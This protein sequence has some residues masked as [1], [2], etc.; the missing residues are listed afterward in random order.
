MKKILIIAY[1]F[2]PIHASGVYR[3]LKFAKYLRGFG[4]EPLI[5]TID[6]VCGHGKDPG[7]LRDLPADLK[8]ER[9]SQWDFYRLVELIK[10]LERRV[11]KENQPPESKAFTAASAEKAAPGKLSKSALSRLKSQLPVFIRDLFFVPDDSIPWLPVAVKA[12]TKIIRQEK[13]DVVMTTSPPQSAHLVG[14]L[15]K[16]MTGTPWVVDFRDLWMDTFDFYDKAFGKWRKPLEA[17]MERKVIAQADRIINISHGES[18]H[19]QAQYSTQPVGKFHVIHNGYDRQD[20]SDKQKL[21]W[22]INEKTLNEKKLIVTYVGT[23]YPTTGDEFFGVLDRMF[24]ERPWLTREFEFRF[25]GHI[26]P[27]YLT[28]FDT[29]AFR[30]CIRMY[31][32]RPHAGALRAMTESDVLLLLQGGGKMN[33]GE[34]PGKVFEYMAANL[35][36]LAVAWPGDVAAILQESGL[37]YVVAPNDEMGIENSLVELFELKKSR[38]QYVY[39]N[40]E[41]IEGFE[42][43]KLTGK[44]AAM[45]DEMVEA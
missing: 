17:W 25:V 33:A 10:K 42:R 28:V 24:R 36:V 41:Y 35:P 3:P 29:S 39:P 44:L 14:L 26:A 20:F 22:N 32:L 5:L 30:K 7:L 31:G 1:Y 18:E 45:L 37:G 9:T 19:L 4:W 38:K 15:T 34:I 40:K 6:A 27:E 21:S 16:M 2:P 13:V 12:A 11:N 8:I 23:L 43:E